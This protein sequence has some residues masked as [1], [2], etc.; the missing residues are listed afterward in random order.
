MVATIFRYGDMRVVMNRQVL[1]MWNSLED[2]KMRFIPDLVGPFVEMALIDHDEIRRNTIPV[3]M[4]MMD[5]ELQSTGDFRRVE[6]ELIDKLDTYVSGGGRGDDRFKDNLFKILSVE[7]NRYPE[8]QKAGVSQ[9]IESI[10]QLLSRLLDFRNV[11]EGEENRNQRMSTISNLLHLY[12][13]ME[14]EEMYIRYIYKLCSMHLQWGNYTEAAFTLMLHAKKLQW[15][16][17]PAPQVPGKYAEAATQRLLKEMLYENIIEYFDKGKLWEYSITVSKELA[18]HYETVVYDY[19]RLSSIYQTIGESFHKIVHSVRAALSYFRVG[20]YGHGFLPSLKNKLFIY[21]GGEY[22]N[23]GDF[24]AR[25][26]AEFPNAQ[27]LK[28][29]TPPDQE[30]LDS[31]GQYIQTCTVEPLPEEPDKFQGKNVAEAIQGFHTHNDVR[32]FRV[33]RPF[34]RGVKD[35]GNEFATLWIERTTYQTAESLPGILRWSEVQFQPQ[36]VELCPIENALESVL[37]RNKDMQRVIAQCQADPAQGVMSLG[38][39]VNGVI[40]AAVN[41]GVAKYEMAFFGSEYLKANAD[42]EELVAKLRDAITHQVEICGEALAVHGRYA[43]ETLQPFQQKM[44]EMYEPLKKKYP[45]EK[46]S[47][48]FLRASFRNRSSPVQKQ[49]Q[50]QRRQDSTETL[51]RPVTVSYSASNVADGG[52]GHRMSERGAR[53][54]LDPLP[55]IPAADGSPT[56]DKRLSEIPRS[57]PAATDDRPS[58]PTKMNKPSRSHTLVDRHQNRHSSADTVAGLTPPPKPARPS[59]ARSATDSAEKRPPKPYRPQSVNYGVSIVNQSSL[60]VGFGKPPK[61]VAYSSFDQQLSPVAHGDFLASSAVV[62]SVCETQI[63]VDVVDPKPEYIP[64]FKVSDVLP[65]DGTLDEFPKREANGPA[66]G[67]AD[68]SVPPARP[69]KLH[70]VKMANQAQSVD[71]LQSSSSAWSVDSVDSVVDSGA[72]ALPTKTSVSSRTSRLSEANLLSQESGEGVSIDS[73]VHPRSETY[74]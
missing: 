28:K 15:H 31:A 46:R 61:Q 71:S 50:Q 59:P 49:Q 27:M 57:S 11:P 48:H 21:R 67:G 39:S 3:F 5:C 10:T 63:E 66:E 58:L 26:T 64:K 45:P 2:L 19:D 72:P 24:N 14:R 25:L 18:L 23:I 43:P 47:L 22:E 16:D 13:E 41:G 38:M 53:S 68:T 51:A 65:M 55:P 9:F 35:K 4:N 36:S 54:I 29:S 44:V 42:H 6:S 37:N 33:D 69:P 70:R 34:H 32:Q 30:I 8:L 74:L 17:F 7:T 40:D 20:F 62:P 60:D 52:R 56:Q 73:T 1:D 12:R